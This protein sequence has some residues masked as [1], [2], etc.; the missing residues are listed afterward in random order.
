MT[1]T[2]P[3]LTNYEGL[4][5]KALL[6][7][8]RGVMAIGA[9]SAK[10]GLRRSTAVSTLEQLE[11]LNLVTSNSA[12]TE[13]RAVNF[14]E[15]EGSSAPKPKAKK[16]A[17]KAPKETR[18]QAFERVLTEATCPLSAADIKERTGF[19][20]I[21]I[22]DC[23]YKARKNGLNIVRDADNNLSLSSEPKP[24]DYRPYIV[25]ASKSDVD[26]I[27]FVPT[28]GMDALLTGDAYQALRDAAVNVTNV[29]TEAP[30]KMAAPVVTD[31]EMD[32]K[33]DEL[34]LIVPIPS[35]VEGIRASFTFVEAAR[36]LISLSV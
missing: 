11:K 27:A 10:S 19:D 4:L 5:M 14:V 2:N 18:I 34:L 23:L 8:P 9:L 33:I 1:A 20:Q 3:T 30:E 36:N 16:K 15:P 12:G 24:D 13:W 29:F 32:R 28:S 6:N 26:K 22:T 17:K 35:T 31:A 21:S 25:K 7:S